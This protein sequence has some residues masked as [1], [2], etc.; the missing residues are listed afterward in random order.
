[1]QRVTPGVGYALGPVEVTLKEIFVPTLYQR[2]REGLPE[3]GIIR[4]PVKQAG[5][6]LTDSTQTAPENWTASCVITGHLV[7]ARR[8]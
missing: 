1:M 2:L 5:L 8:G 4:L 6:A 3:Q 7:A